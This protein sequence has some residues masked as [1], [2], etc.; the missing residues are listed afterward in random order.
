M[1][2]VVF[3]PTVALAAFTASSTSPN[4]SMIVTLTVDDGVAIS[5]AADATMSPNLS[6]TNSKAT[7]A[8]KW[9]VVTN[10]AGGYELTVLASASPALVKI[11]PNADNFG[12]Y[13]GTG[14]TWA[15]TTGN[16]EFGFSAFGADNSTQTTGDCGLYALGV[17]GDPSATLLKYQAFSNTTATTIASSTAVTSADGTDTNICF[18]A[19]QNGVFAKSGIYHA[20]ITATA[21]VN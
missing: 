15:V 19:E 7:G 20:T 9:S 10:N 4:D 17:G 14:S 16:K 13:T 6:I 3:E 21:T 8:S 12:D 11:A 1:L 18:G 5:A 2:Y